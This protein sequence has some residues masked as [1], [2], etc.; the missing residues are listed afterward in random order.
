MSADEMISILK[1]TLKPSRFEHTLGVADTAKK[2]AEFY[3]CDTE[4]AYVAGLLHDC[5]KN[6]PHD[7]A[8]KMCRENSVFL[9]EIC[10]QEPSLIH[11]VLGAFLAETKFGVSDRDILNAIYY[12]T[13]GHENMPLLTKIIYI[14]D[15]IEPTR[16]HAGVELLRKTVYE[17][18]DEALVRSI[19]ATIRHIINKGGLLD[20][21]TVAARNYLLK[22]A[23][24]T[25]CAE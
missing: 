22:K 15:A 14:S 12:H 25:V 7:E 24:C 13:T 23:P 3:G 2:L 1:D 5:A 17:N 11:A 18:L 4:K 16:T 9:K 8:I 20:C 21:D 19:D 10:I 6:I